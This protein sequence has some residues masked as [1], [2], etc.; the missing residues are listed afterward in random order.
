ME[1][2]RTPDG[3][4]PL[5]IHDEEVPR[6][7]ARITRSYQ[8]ARWTDGRTFVWMARR[9]GAGRGEGSSG[10]QFDVLE[11]NTGS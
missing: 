8:Y 3:D 11:P 9:K 6:E 4:D 1:P 10:L 2:G 5:F 7:G